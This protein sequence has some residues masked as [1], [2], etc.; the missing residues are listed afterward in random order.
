[1]V[2][3]DTF[4]ENTEKSDPLHSLRRIRIAT[5]NKNTQTSVLI[6]E[7]GFFSE[8]LTFQT[9]LLS[10]MWIYSLEPKQ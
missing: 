7:I 5:V 8:N 9:E 10:L 4:P 2:S 1:M 3:I 6:T